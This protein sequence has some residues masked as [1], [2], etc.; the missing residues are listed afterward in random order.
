MC[1]I[2]DQLYS[3]TFVREIGECGNIESLEA[4]AIMRFV[5]L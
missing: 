2:Y 3:L 1:L 4:L 5:E